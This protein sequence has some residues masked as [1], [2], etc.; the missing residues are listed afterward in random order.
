MVKVRNWGNLFCVIADEDWAAASREADARMAHILGRASYNSSL[1]V[2]YVCKYGGV[3]CGTRSQA[4][5]IAMFLNSET[6]R[7]PHA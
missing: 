3:V 6:Q 2:G 7:N 1:T 4:A 5:Q